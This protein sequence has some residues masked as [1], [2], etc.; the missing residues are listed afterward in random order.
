MAP[1]RWMGLTG[2]KCAVCLIW[3]LSLNACDDA[4]ASDDAAGSGDSSHEHEHDHAHGSAGNE[5]ASPD[6]GATEAMH[7]HA[8]D[9]TQAVVDDAVP[10]QL[11][12]PAG[13]V[14]GDFQW[15]LPSGF[16]L[17]VVPIDN[18]MS[19]AKVEL[20]RRLFYD[21]RLSANETQSCATCHKQELAF[22]DG[23]AQGLGSTGELHPRSP[24]AIINLAYAPSVTWANTEF[25]LDKT[26]EPLEHQTEAPLYGVRPIE[27]GMESKAMLEERIRNISEYEPWFAQAFPRDEQPMTAQN[28]ARAIAAFE[29]VL[30]SGNSPYD[31]YMAGDDS[32]LTAS[33]VR[34]YELFNG[35]KFECFHCHSQF[36]LTDHVHWQGKSELELRFHN[37]GLYNIDG[38]GA[39]PEPNT[40]VYSQT[41]DPKD[42]GMFKAPTLRNIA[43]T[44]PYMHDGSIQT[45]SEV[46][47]HYAAGGRTLREGPY[48]GAG[49]KSALKDPLVRGFEM[50]E[51][52]RA[53]LLAFLESLTDEEFLTNPAFSDPW[54]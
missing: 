17:P 21:R 25:S 27:L 9:A 52:E 48:A 23:R 3:S 49:S 22:S 18:P 1:S 30:I 8:H 42:M 39:Y 12:P 31:R 7:E 46:L 16:P 29:R 36:S 6:A 54:Q 24:M 34:G 35:E 10:E 37:T 28:I 33:Q 40:G 20:G 51:Q 15:N 53:D 13:T 19:T 47:D 32:A 14:E 45:L 4:A 43:V 11:K 5:A 38:R 2:A 26:S 44:A 41:K 50:S